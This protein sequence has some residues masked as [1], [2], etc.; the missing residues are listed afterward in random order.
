MSAIITDDKLSA[1]LMRTIKS[2]KLIHSQQ[3]LLRQTF[4]GIKTQHLILQKSN[5]VSLD[6]YSKAFLLSATTLNYT[7]L[8]LT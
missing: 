2:N 6:D 3:L 5:C 7:V 8:D 1:V 4:H